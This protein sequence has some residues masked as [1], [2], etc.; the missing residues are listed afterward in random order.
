[1][2]KGDYKKGKGKGV[3]FLREL[4][5]HRG[6]ACVLWPYATEYNGY[7]NFGYL[8]RM[9]RAHKFMCELTHSPRPTPKHEAA[10]SCG[11]A[12]CVNP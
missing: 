2:P 6:R 11:I 3:T 12:L 1:M 10:H 7:G 5:G 9:L 4:V 8:G